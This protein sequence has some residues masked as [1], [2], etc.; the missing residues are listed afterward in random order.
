MR[1]Y[2]KCIGCQG[3][4]YTLSHKSRNLFVLCLSFMNETIEIEVSFIDGFMD[5]KLTNSPTCDTDCIGRSMF[6]VDARETTSFMDGKAIPSP[7]GT[8]RTVLSLACCISSGYKIPCCP[9]KERKAICLSIKEVL[10]PFQ[11]DCLI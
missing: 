1:K 10:P 6:Q 8:S 3:C 4:M 7:S 11:N 5:F 2:L 9:L